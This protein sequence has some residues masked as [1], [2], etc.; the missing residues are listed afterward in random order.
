MKNEGYTTEVSDP[1]VAADDT[2][3]EDPDAGVLYGR[4]IIETA[5]DI[6]ALEGVTEIRGHL[7]ISGNEFTVVTLPNSLRT[8]LGGINSI[9]PTMTELHAPGLQILSIYEGRALD[10]RAS[11]SIS[12]IDF[13]ELT[14]TGELPFDYIPITELNLPKLVSVHSIEL[15]Y[16]LVPNDELTFLDLSA[17]QVVEGSLSIDGAQLSEINLPALRS[18]GSSI[19]V[20]DMPALESIDLSVLE[21]LASGTLYVTGNSALTDVRLGSLAAGCADLSIVSNPELPACLF[22]SYTD[23]CTAFTVSDND[24]DALCD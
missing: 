9:S 12:V 15:G 1:D 8:I 3:D 17:L 24:D 18:V 13:P 19:F 2:P 5:E 20:G 22:D 21:Q 11:P 10:L 4:V 7:L 16:H 14:Q 23:I 6:A